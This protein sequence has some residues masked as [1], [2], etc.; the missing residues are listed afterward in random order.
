MI[1]NYNN[2]YV[3]HNAAYYSNYN[4]I[5]ESIRIVNNDHV[6]WWAGINKKITVTEIKEQ[7]LRIKRLLIETGHTLVF[8]CSF[9]VGQ[10]NETNQDFK[11]TI[12]LFRFIMKNMDTVSCFFFPMTPYPGSDV[13][14]I[15]KEKY[16]FTDLDFYNEFFKDNERLKII[17]N[18]SNIRDKKIYINLKKIKLLY[19][20]LYFRKQNFSNKFKLIKDRIDHYKRKGVLIDV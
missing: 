18:I 13:Y 14:E 20:W 16:Q 9:M 6:N 19:L 10:Y 4:L 3:T 1:K 7:I 8:G 17:Y 11:K 5:Y 12:K 15:I 2:C